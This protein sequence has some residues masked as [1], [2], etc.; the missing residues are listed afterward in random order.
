MFPRL[1]LALSIFVLVSCYATQER[2]RKDGW[3]NT[4]FVMNRLLTHS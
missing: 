3:Q 4:R 2:A 1:I